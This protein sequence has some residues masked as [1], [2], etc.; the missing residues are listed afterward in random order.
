MPTPDSSNQI[1]T[2]THV[3]TRGLTNGRGWQTHRRIHG[4]RERERDKTPPPHTHTHAQT[5]KDTNTHKHTHTHTHYS[6]GTRRAG[7]EPQ[8]RGRR[9]CFRPWRRCW[10]R[11]ARDPP[12]R[13]C[14]TAEQRPGRGRARKEGKERLRAHGSISIPHHALPSTRKNDPTSPSS[15]TTDDAVK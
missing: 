9:S 2:H 11:E 14:P 5:H 13:A 4:E 3:Q 1:N 12:S 6:S 7:S 10:T 8:P 15:A